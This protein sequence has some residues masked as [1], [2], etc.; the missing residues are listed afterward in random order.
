MSTPRW[1][2]F[3][4]LDGTLLDHETY[5]WDA[6]RPALERCRRLNAAVVL[7]SSK[8][9]A[10]LA[11]LRGEMGLDH[12]FI[13]ENGAGIFVPQGYFPQ[14]A[15]GAEQVD[16]LERIT[17]GAPYRDLLSDL[18]AAAK[19]SGVPIR[20]F[21]QMDEAEIAQRTALPLER[22]HLAKQREFVEPFV[23]EGGADPAPLLAAIERRGRSWTR[24]GRFF[25]ILGGSNKARAVLA[26][27]AL[28][29]AQG[30]VRTIGLGDAE[31]DAEML[32]ACDHAVVVRGKR[33]AQ[34]AALVPQAHQTEQA[35]PAGWNQAVLALLSGT[36][37]GP[38]PGA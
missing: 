24:G 31:N 4:D 30:R 18:T 19:E 8:T 16:G 32:R 9:R 7:C 17:L 21:S 23:V 33:S 29:E 6:A 28:Y 3:T 13:T 14:P 25:H 37:V 38:P 5:S 12:P 35:G 26:L 20:G 2:I 1:V 15:A 27:R 34:L 36:P 10:E 11:W 22:A